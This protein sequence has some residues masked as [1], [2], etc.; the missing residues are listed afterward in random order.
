MEKLLL[1]IKV[2]IVLILDFISL[3]LV[4][5]L[6]YVKATMSA[7]PSLVLVTEE[8]QHCHDDTQKYIYDLLTQR[9]YYVSSK[10]EFGPYTV[11]LA[12]IPYKIGIIIESVPCQRKQR[13]FHHNDWK[14]LSFS[15]EKLKR[16]SYEVLRII[17]KAIQEKQKTSNFFS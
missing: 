10:I 15:E 9:G 16:D 7:Q 13:F 8:R 6:Q 17:L 11:D 1:V 3:S 14:V 4:I 2:D 12:L 5:F